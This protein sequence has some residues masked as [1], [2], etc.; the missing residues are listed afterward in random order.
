MSTATWRWRDHA[1]RIFDIGYEQLADVPFDTVAD[2]L[3]VVPSMVKLQ[4]YRS[5]WGLVS[6]Y[7]QDPRLRQAFS[8]QPL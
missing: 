2:M 6:S 3:R 1:R 4:S 7:I 8:F 5:V